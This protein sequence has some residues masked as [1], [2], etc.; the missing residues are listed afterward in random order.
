MIKKE[1][2][3]GVRTSTTKKIGRPTEE[4]TTQFYC[5]VPNSIFKEVSDHVHSAVKARKELFK[6][7]QT[8]IEKGDII[9]DEFDNVILVDYMHGNIDGKKTGIYQGKRVD[10]KLNIIPDQ[11]GTIITGTTIKIIKKHDNL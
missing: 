7:R 4:E 11:I 9:S 10:N 2:R 5:R 8:S 3:G 1:N 6:K